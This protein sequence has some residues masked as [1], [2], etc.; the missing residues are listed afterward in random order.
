MD[1]NGGGVAGTTGQGRTLPPER[2]GMARPHAVR[3]ITQPQRR[4]LIDGLHQAKPP[5]GGVPSPPYAG[6]SILSPPQRARYCIVS[7][8]RGGTDLIPLLPITKNQRNGPVQDSIRGFVDLPKMCCA[9]IECRTKPTGSSVSNM[10][11]M[12]STLCVFIEVVWSKK[13]KK[14]PPWAES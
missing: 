6:P 4:P 11:V 5:N 12:I 10:A 7:S 1:D 14:A 13:V 8:G 3:L 2:P 9:G